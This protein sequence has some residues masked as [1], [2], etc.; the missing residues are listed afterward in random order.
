MDRACKKIPSDLWVRQCFL[1]G[2]PVDSTRV[3]R[4]HLLE[5]ES[6]ALPGWSTYLQDQ[7]HPYSPGPTRS[8]TEGCCRQWNRASP[9]K[10]QS[11]GQALLI[12]KR[13]RR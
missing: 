13:A 4:T 9:G 11:K 10:R 5:R 6:K 3:I 1:L 2:T 7:Q 12:R 8:W